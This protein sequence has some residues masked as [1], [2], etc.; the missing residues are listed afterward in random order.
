[1]LGLGLGR[2]TLAQSRKVT[3]SGGGGTPPPQ[4]T[5]PRSL[6]LYGDSFAQRS[7]DVTGSPNSLT[8]G[9]V[10]PVSGRWPTPETR[11]V[12]GVTWGFGSWLSAITGRYRTPYHLNYGIGGLNTGQLVQD[13]VSNDYLGKMAAQ[14][15][16]DLAGP[17]APHGVIFQGGTNDSV[18]TF[19]T[20][21]SYSN[22]RTICQRIAAFG[23]PVFLSTILP[24]GSALHPA[25]RLDAAK[26]D[27]V[28]ALNDRLLADLAGEPGLEGLVHLIDPRADF[29]DLAGEP[30]DVID[31]L[32][33]DG[34]HLSPEGCRRL[35]SAY[36]VA[37][38]AAFPSVTTD[39]VA[40]THPDPDNFIS[41]P[42]MA[43]SGGT[44]TVMGNSS[45]N[46]GF[47]TSGT[48]PDGWTMRTTNYGMSAWNA[49]DPGNVKG[50]VTVA[51]PPADVGNAIEVVV[52]SD[53]SGTNNPNTRGLEIK[54]DFT[55]PD[56]ATLPVG[57]YFE[58]VCR[59]ELSAHLNCRG[60]S[61]EIRLNEPDGVLRDIRSLRAAPNGLTGVEL[62]PTV[63]YVGGNALILRTPPRARKAGDY[64]TITFA[65]MLY[66]A[67][68]QS[69]I[70]ATAR[71][72]QAA[73]R[74]V[75]ASLI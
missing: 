7:Q 17:M 54:T 44:V 47:T 74:V 22:I 3:L 24:R 52:A 64:G 23:I 65:V 55:L 71:V 56:I 11:D 27:L 37:L 41:N 4:Q 68:Q 63:D 43:G 28:N 14:L 15:S 67:G 33:Y 6:A 30:N 62:D 58:G 31:A 26:I 36:A 21:L 60:A 50:S 53:S 72:S 59:V 19:S 51:T 8:T 5:P 10:Q 61:L 12:G 66:F 13:G 29:R 73:V 45:T 38:D 18:A 39:G 16:A 69:Q 70:E 57:S 25:Y 32:T 42:L 2:S 34:L 40:E 75:D 9:L 46:V 48:A 49:P 20:Q 1:M 35:A